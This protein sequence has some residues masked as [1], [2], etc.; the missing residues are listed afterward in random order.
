[1][2]G[3]FILDV[4]RSE[5]GMGGI[6]GLME[7]WNGMGWDETGDVGKA[8]GEG[9]WKRRRKRKMEKG[10][11]KRT[12]STEMLEMLEMLVSHQVSGIISWYN[13]STMYIR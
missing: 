2:A 5:R 12:S 10:K 11:G 7:A 6:D 8:E 13:C 3:D 9:G 4:D 1:M